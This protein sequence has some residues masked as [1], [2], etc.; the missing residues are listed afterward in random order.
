[1]VSGGWTYITRRAKETKISNIYSERNTRQARQEIKGQF[2][3][4]QGEKGQ[5]S[6]GMRQALGFLTV[7]GNRKCEFCQ[8][9]G[10][11]KDRPAK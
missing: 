8:R 3:M 4:E 6:R 11:E 5:S 7:T 10:G 1:M 2:D 9:Y